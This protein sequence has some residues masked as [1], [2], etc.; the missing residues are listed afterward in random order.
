MSSTGKIVFGAVGFVA[1]VV[2]A[3]AVGVAMAAEE[4]APKAVVA[5]DAGQKTTA[6]SGT[7][8]DT[9]GRKGPMQ[10]KVTQGEGEKW[11][12]KF[13]G[14]NEGQGPNKPYECAFALP[15]K[16]DGTT[17]NLSGTTDVVRIGQH[18]VNI[19]ITDKTLEGKFKKTDGK[20]GGSFSMTSAK[21]AP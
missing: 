17:L 13:N 1:A 10:C 7:F 9:S 18:E 19:A 4:P 12:L 2:G 20:N 14:N 8:S 16:K 21:S 5:T 3:V 6:Y 11:S 15:G